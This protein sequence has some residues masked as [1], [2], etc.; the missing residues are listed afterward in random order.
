MLEATLE[1]RCFSEH[2]FIPLHHKTHMID[3]F[4]FANKNRQ[5][6]VRTEEVSYFSSKWV[7]VARKVL[8]HERF[9]IH[10]WGVAINVRIINTLI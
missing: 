6:F 7:Q 9:S 4:V 5:I 10:S 8:E 1:V 2:M 3:T